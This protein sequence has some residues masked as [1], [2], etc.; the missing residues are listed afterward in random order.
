[1]IF[2]SLERFRVLF[3]WNSIGLIIWELRKNAKLKHM[4]FFKKI[5]GHVT[6]FF[7]S[8]LTNFGDLS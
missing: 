5:N 4:F 3:Y 1:M 7:F 2:F 8:F 6:N